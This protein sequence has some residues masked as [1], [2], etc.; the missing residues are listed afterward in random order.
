MEEGKTS[1]SCQNWDWTDRVRFYCATHSKQ[2][3]F[4]WATTIHLECQR[5]DIEEQANL[6]DL[7]KMVREGLAEVVQ[8]AQEL[9]AD[10]HIQ[11]LSCQI[12][13]YQESL[14][15]LEN[16]VSVLCYPFI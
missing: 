1:L 14:Q 2:L 15:S 6:R 13:K 10:S 12:Q 16:K 3:W 11:D 7:I 5:E 4:K 8:E 9:Q